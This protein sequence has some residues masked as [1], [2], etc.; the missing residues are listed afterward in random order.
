MFRIMGVMTALNAKNPF[1]TV[2]QAAA[3]HDY[4]AIRIPA[5]VSFIF[6]QSIYP[7][8]LYCFGL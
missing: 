2:V 6:H 4:F 7:I 1:V 3:S 5:S 8:Q